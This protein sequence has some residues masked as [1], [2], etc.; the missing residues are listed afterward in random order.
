MII[1]APDLLAVLVGVLVG[2]I[3]G[4]IGG[5]GSVLAVPLLVY[6]V[7]VQS[8]HVAIATS[9]IAVALSAF[10]NL[11]DHARRGHVYWPVALTFAVSGASGAALGCVFG[12][13]T[14]GQKLLLLFGIAMVAIAAAMALRRDG[15]GGPHVQMQWETAPR[16]AGTGFVVGALAGFFGIG[17]GVLVVPGLIASASLPMILAIGSS[18]VSVTAFALTTATIYGLYGLTDWRLV[19]LLVSGG[20]VG[21][22]AGSRLATM[23]AARKRALSLLFAAVVAAV[24][25]YVIAR[26]IMTLMT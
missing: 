18:L 8:P 6:V 15:G 11:I 22:L 5:S 2:L 12:Q 10:A 7:G 13:H 23:L 20:I 3:L 9:S 19:A 25:V 4:L 16:V 21:G 24:G 14:E 26:G 17:G 1:G